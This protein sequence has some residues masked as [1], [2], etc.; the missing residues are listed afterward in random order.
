MKNEKIQDTNLPLIPMPKKLHTKFIR[1]TKI[2]VKL[3]YCITLR[4]IPK[5]SIKI[6]KEE[7]EVYQNL[8]RLT[9]HYLRKNSI[10]KF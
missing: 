10:N 2:M 8:R 6:S 3:I 5:V 1:E 7:I 4:L 9:L